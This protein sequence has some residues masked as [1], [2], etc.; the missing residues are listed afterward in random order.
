MNEFTN[1]DKLVTS[2]SS[3]FIGASPQLSD[4]DDIT[5]PAVNGVQ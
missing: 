3:S 5:Q 2:S 1:I 4:D